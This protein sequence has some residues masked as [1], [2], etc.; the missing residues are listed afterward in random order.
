M[1]KSCPH[2]NPSHIPPPQDTSIVRK[3]A[4]EKCEPISS[5]ED[6]SNEPRTR[7]TRVATAESVKTILPDLP[8]EIILI[9]AQYLPPSSLM[10]L[11]Y[12]C[13]TI[14]NKT[15]VSIEQLLGTKNQI[16]QLSGSSLE[17][18]LPKRVGTT[19]SLPI[20]TRNVYH[21]ERLKLLYML[22]RDKKVPPSKAVCTNC[23]DTHDRSLSSSTTLA[24][25][26]CERSC[27]G[28]VGRV[29]I[30]PH[31]M[32]D[33]NLVTTSAE[34]QGVHAC[35]NKRV[36]VYPTY[37]DVYDLTPNV[38]WPIVILH[39]NNDAPSKKVVDDI[40]GLMDTSV[41][42]HLR[43]TDPFVSRLYSPDCKKLRKRGPFPHC[44]CSS[45][46][47]QL[48]QPHLGGY[49]FGKVKYR[50]LYNG[51]KCE[52][53]GTD[54]Y[55]RIEADMDGQETLELVVQRNIRMFRGCTDRTWIE[56]VNDP[57]EFDKPEREWYV[58][59]DEICQTAQDTC[60]AL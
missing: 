60:P 26:S 25:P 38:R 21:S 47:W 49:V 15:G 43:Y 8:T 3:T 10:S 12:S 16:A 6:I 13:R 41:C 42:K 51:S 58:A 53:C 37:S 4:Q 1:A 30:C 57:S 5:G 2:D 18:N 56:Q 29:W 31:W 46:V 39:G 48:S 44:Q 24:Q 35:G 28:S 33:H 22:Y 59:T 23:A 14:H 7:M 20:M 36:F 55:F 27:L 52:S 50:N 40:L 11:S 32:F 19:W 17:D 34:P 45:C 9:I 54:V